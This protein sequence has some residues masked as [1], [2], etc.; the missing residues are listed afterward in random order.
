MAYFGLTVKQVKRFTEISRFQT[1]IW[2]KRT[3]H[4]SNSRPIFKF[5]KKTIIS[6]FKILAEIMQFS[7]HAMFFSTC[8]INQMSSLFF[9]SVWPNLFFHSA[10]IYL[11]KNIMQKNDTNPGSRVIF[12]LNHSD[13][14][15]IKH[16]TGP[17]KTSKCRTLVFSPAP[18]AMMKTSPRSVCTET[19]Q[20]RVVFLSRAA[21]RTSFILADKIRNISADT[22]NTRLCSRVET[23]ELPESSSLH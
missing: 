7:F 11:W 23:H 9:R 13:F 16:P 3:A 22:L 15:V 19:L 1:E 12:L 4:T 5:K 18:T 10:I 21:N 6:V 17:L 14:K 8:C 2:W 20:S